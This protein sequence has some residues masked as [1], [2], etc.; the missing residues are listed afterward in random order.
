[1]LIVIIDKIQKEFWKQ[2]FILKCI[3]KKMSAGKGVC[4]FTEPPPPPR[5]GPVKIIFKEERKG[6][7]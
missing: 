6:N 3:Q 4:T 5:Y 2:A 1:M 7:I